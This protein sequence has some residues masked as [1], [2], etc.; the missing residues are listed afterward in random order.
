MSD[1]M[2]DPIDD[3][4]RKMEVGFKT[5]A[6]ALTANGDNSGSSSSE[7]EALS[8]AIS[9]KQ[10]TR[11]LYETMTQWGRKLTTHW[12]VQ[13]KDENVRG[14]NVSCGACAID[15]CRGDIAC[16]TMVGSMDL[17]WTAIHKEWGEG[18][19][20]KAMEK[21]IETLIRNDGESLPS[22]LGDLNSRSLASRGQQSSTSDPEC[23]IWNVFLG[24]LSEVWETMGESG[25]IN[26]RLWIVR[27]C[28]RSH[29]SALISS[30]ML[31]DLQ[32]AWPGF[33]IMPEQVPTHLQMF[34][35]STIAQCTTVAHRSR[36][37]V[38]VTLKRTSRQNLTSPM[39]RP[40]WQLCQCNPNT[41]WLQRW[42]I[43]RIDPQPINHQ[44]SCNPHPQPD[45]NQSR[46]RPLPLNVSQGLAIDREL[47]FL[48]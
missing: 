5:H 19:V 12:D 22:M 29:R 2:V 7:Y 46:M 10:Y 16:T 41:L 14:L 6:A 37:L 21:L 9:V 34:L 11:Q 4:S 43:M 25:E 30:Q 36:Q 1:G 23:T 38:P 39:M 44:S 32:S 31:A 42:Y 47:W 27:F 13:K 40:G 45:C 24:R 33:A 26:R 18:W 28:M 35:S 8:D 48:L 20:A 17:Q 15:T 3:L